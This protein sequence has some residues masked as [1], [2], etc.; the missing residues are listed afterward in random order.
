M[1]QLFILTSFVVLT[2]HLQ[3]IKMPLQLQQDFYV[4][5]SKNLPGNKENSTGNLRTIFLLVQ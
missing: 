2:G 4:V 5:N 3:K 1:P